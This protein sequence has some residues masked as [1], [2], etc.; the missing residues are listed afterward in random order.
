MGFKNKDEE[1]KSII[2]NYRMWK[3]LKQMSLDREI[4]IKHIILDMMEKLGYI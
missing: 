1:K 3:I 2:V 4:S